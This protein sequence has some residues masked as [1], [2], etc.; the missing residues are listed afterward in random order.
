MKTRGGTYGTNNIDM[1]LL[2]SHFQRRSTTSRLSLPVDGV[3]DDAVESTTVQEST[4][5]EAR[6]TS[7]DAAHNN[8]TDDA[9]TTPAKSNQQ[10]V[11]EK[12]V[13]PPLNSEQV[14]SYSKQDVSNANVSS[15][16]LGGSRMINNTS[17]DG[18][19]KDLSTTKKNNPANDVSNDPTSTTI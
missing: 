4:V 19:D 1:P 2:D 12:E 14:K 6:T 18:N 7:N 9:T 8:A 15:V 17:M 10:S 5:E 3:K 11:E 13:E 16:D